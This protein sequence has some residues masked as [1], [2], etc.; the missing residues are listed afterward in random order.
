MMLVHLPAV[1][2]AGKPFSI[3]ECNGVLMRAVDLREFRRPTEV[4]RFIDGM[5]NDKLE[6]TGL[7]SSVGAFLAE[8]DPERG[9][10]NKELTER[11]GVSKGLTTRVVR[12][13]QDMGLVDV[14]LD[15]RGQRITLTGRGAEART[16]VVRAAEECIEYLYSG[17]TDEE[18]VQM[19]GM[20]RKIEDAMVR[21]EGASGREDAGDPWRP[22]SSRWM[23]WRQSVFQS[24]RRPIPA[25][26]CGT[27]SVYR[28]SRPSKSG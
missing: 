8:L 21:Y 22:P 3:F 4:K 14:E 19:T 7:T 20:Y 27:V 18:I 2:A 24:I 17:F 12:Q 10:T 26:C 28:R 11:V 1:P 6:G 9:M 16:M 13:L 23:T 15:G 5:M 25:M